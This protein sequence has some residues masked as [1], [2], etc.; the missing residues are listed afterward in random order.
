MYRAVRD[1]LHAEVESWKPGHTREVLPDLWKEVAALEPVCRNLDA[2]E[3]VEAAEQGEFPILPNTP[4]V[5][6][7]A[8]A[9][10]TGGGHD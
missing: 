9:E 2:T 10:T 5:F 1:A 8:Q 7:H 4:G 6:R 3:F